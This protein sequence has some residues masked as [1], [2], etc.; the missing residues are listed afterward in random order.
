MP[1]VPE[2]VGDAVESAQEV[3][4][5]PRRGRVREFGAALG[6]VG[7]MEPPFADEPRRVEVHIGRVELRAPEHRRSEPPPALPSFTPNPLAR[8]YLDR[9]L[10]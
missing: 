3:S 2:L 6:H 9:C 5:Q 8:R 7:A 4:I 1:S 10:Y